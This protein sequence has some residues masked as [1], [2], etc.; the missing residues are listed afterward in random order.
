M[1]EN[2]RT[3]YLGT[4]VEVFGPKGAFCQPSK[5]MDEYKVLNASEQLLSH[6]AES[7]KLDSKDRQLS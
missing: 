1:K 4:T 6:E 7:E 5:A 2:V 3:I